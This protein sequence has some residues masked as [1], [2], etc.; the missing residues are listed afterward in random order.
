MRCSSFIL[1]HNLFSIIFLI[2]FFIH[3][4]H[5]SCNFVYLINFTKKRQVKRTVY[6][7]INRIDKS[8][9]RYMHY[10]IINKNTHICEMFLSPREKMC[11]LFHSSL[12]LSLRIRCLNFFLFGFRYTC[13]FHL[14]KGERDER[15]IKDKVKR[16]FKSSITYLCSIKKNYFVDNF[17]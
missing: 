11:S 10:I 2:I 16:R 7:D 6:C 9:F 13:I 14:H 5:Q 8:T 17:K 3:R 4:L 12:S 15:K 1:S